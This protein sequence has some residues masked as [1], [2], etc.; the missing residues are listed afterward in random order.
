MERESLGAMGTN[1]AQSGTELQK[2]T[3]SVSL[4]V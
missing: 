4:P 2:S 1:G 3:F